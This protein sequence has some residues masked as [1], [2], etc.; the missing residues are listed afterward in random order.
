MNKL[1]LVIMISLLAISTRA[2]EMTTG[3]WST[4]EENTKIETYQK[5]GLWYGQI[6]SSDNPKAVIGTDILIGFKK[7]K[8][9]WVGK[10]YAVKRDKTLDA[11]IKPQK[12]EMNITVSAGLFKKQL[13]WKR[14]A[15]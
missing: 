11:I 10:L 14:D 9:I 4:G 3:V 6:I 7:E 15:N 2:Q 5:D 12:D 8:E 13:S 1:I